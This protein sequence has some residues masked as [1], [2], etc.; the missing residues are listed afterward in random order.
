MAPP[1]ANALSF[2]DGVQ[3]TK[4]YN[5]LQNT[6]FDRAAAAV[7]RR[8]AMY[9]T[10]LF[11]SVIAFPLLWGGIGS[12]ALK[13]PSALEQRGTRFGAALVALK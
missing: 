7:T 3:E 13:L 2:A 4:R 1:H 12:K 5:E 11:G 9:S 8:E 6:F 10:L